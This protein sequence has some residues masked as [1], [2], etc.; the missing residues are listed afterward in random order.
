[1]YLPTSAMRTS[2]S[3]LSTHAASSRHGPSAD[4]VTGSVSF[5]RRAMMAVAPCASSSRGTW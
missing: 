1:M 3:K 5:S 2:T 4:G